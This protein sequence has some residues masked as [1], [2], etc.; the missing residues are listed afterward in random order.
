MVSGSVWRVSLECLVGA[1]VKST[2][3]QAIPTTMR[4]LYKSTV[5]STNALFLHFWRVAEWCLEGV[6]R[7]SGGCLK[8]VWKCVVSDYDCLAKVLVINMLD[9]TQ[10]LGL[11][12]CASSCALSP[13]QL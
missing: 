3:R 7:V 4:L 11:K 2:L 9:Q 5:F 6:W 1:L 8:G 10:K 13:S 12:A